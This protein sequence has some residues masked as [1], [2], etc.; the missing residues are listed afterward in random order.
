MVEGIVEYVEEFVFQAET[1]G[2]LSD[3]GLIPGSDD[4]QAAMY[5]ALDLL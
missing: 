5:E 1:G 4:D 3:E 2:A